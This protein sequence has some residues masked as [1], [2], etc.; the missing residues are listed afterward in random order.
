MP[1]ETTTT[2]HA[3]QQ[4]DAA[5]RPSEAIVE[6]LAGG[7]DPEAVQEAIQEIAAS[8]ETLTAEELDQIVEAVN[9]APTEVKKQFEQ[10][11]NIFTAGLDNYVP[12]DSNVTVGQRRALVAIGAVLAATPAMAMRRK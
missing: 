2:T 12:A 10:E 5:D 4:P 11:V 1:Q 6:A 9:K 3:V 8:L 7:Q